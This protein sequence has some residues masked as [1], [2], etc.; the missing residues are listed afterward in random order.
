M[1]AESLLSKPN[2]GKGRM[3]RAILAV[4]TER[5]GELPT[6]GRFI[7]TN[8]RVAESCGSRGRVNLGVAQPTTRAGGL[9]MIVEGIRDV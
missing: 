1:D 4:L 2:T 5:C 3:Q 8:L 6:S 7:F 9:A